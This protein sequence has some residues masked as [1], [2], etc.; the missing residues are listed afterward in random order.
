MSKPIRISTQTRANWLI[1][2]AVFIGIL[3]LIAAALLGD[4]AVP[5]RRPAKGSA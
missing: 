5:G 4:H 1:D 3:T 2:A